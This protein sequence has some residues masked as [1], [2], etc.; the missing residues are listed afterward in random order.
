MASGGSGGM[1]NNP[2]PVQC[3]KE[4]QDL[5]RLRKEESRL[6]CSQRKQNSRNPKTSPQTSD[7]SASSSWSKP[8]R[9]SLPAKTQR[10]SAESCRSGNSYER[11]M[12]RPGP[13]RD[14]EKEKRRLQNV[15]S[16]GKESSPEPLKPEN[17]TEDIDR[18]QEV[19]NEI[20][21][22]Q[23]FLADMAALGQEQQYVHIINAEISQNIHEL[24]LLDQARRHK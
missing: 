14:L 18:Y 22:R 11:E 20:E 3:S 24:E 15:M 12:F 16:T 4:V 7:P 17:T 23:Q 5:M 13:T 10:R 9:V 19:L 1:W 2:R 8:A 6:T 21:E